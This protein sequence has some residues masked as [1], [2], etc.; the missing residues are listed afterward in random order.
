[1]IRQITLAF[2]LACWCLVSAW[3]QQ[4]VI[5][6]GGGAQNT[7]DAAWTSSTGLN[8]AV[9]LI[10]N[11]AIYNSIL[12]YL[13]QGSTITA[14]VVTFQA[15]IDN[16]TY[17]G[18]QCVAIGTTTI[19][20]PTY[21]LVA[22]TNAA[23]LCPINAPYFQLKLTTAITGSGTVTVQHASQTL[24]AVGLLAGSETLAAGSNVIG[25]V[26][27][28]GTWNVRAQDGA[29]NA[30]TSNST[31]FSS[32]YGLDNNLLGTLGTAFSTAGKVDVKA[33]DADIATLG[34]K[35]DAKST[36]TDT[37]A[38]TVMQVLKEISAMEQ[39]PAS[40]AATNAG[41][42]EVQPDGTTATTTNA[43]S[44]C[45]LVSAAS[46][47]A[48]NC[49]G[50]AGNVYGFRFINTTATLYYLR[51]YNTSSSPTC[52]SATGFIETIPIPA[53]ASGGI[54]AIEPMG[55][56]YSTGISFCFTGGSSSTDT[57]NAATGV[58]GTVLYR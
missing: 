11:T 13:N 2:V 56:G 19:M 45:T 50:S 44:R 46:T 55:E 39:A 31:T 21:T 52:S 37:T 12:I 57:T 23:F 25:A 35:A 58:F 43:A 9:T 33:A 53:S 49:K 24:P 22:S 47:N 42:F 34:A 32:K 36:A 14:G 17:I 38:I 10:S 8:T 5:A 20:G 3:A 15:S 27:E 30:L 7:S 51:M 4:P 29:G 54:V 1:V 18:V 6:Q 40:Q 48:T 41:T 28:S 16:S 26:T